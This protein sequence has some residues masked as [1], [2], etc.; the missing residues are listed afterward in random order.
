MS[1]ATKTVSPVSEDGGDDRLGGRVATV[2]G[3][4][5]AVA[6]VF[7]GV[8]Y[9]LGAVLVAGEIRHERVPLRD[10]L[11]LIP[12]SQMLARGMSVVLAS[13]IYVLAAVVWLGSSLWF[14]HRLDQ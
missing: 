14:G 8:L 6:A 7:V 1:S 9:V 13:P 12:F 11:P 5:P 10:A 4:A 2:L 3:V